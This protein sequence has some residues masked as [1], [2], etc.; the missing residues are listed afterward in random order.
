[1]RAAV[2]EEYGEPLSIESVD[3]PDAEPDGAVVELEA[4]G[5]CRSDWHGWQGDWDWLGLKPPK[6]QILGHEPA[7]RVVEVGPDVERVSEGDHVA[8]PFNIGDGV[9]HECRRG[10]SN[11]CEN[12][13]P[14]GFAEPVPGAFAE[15]VHSQSQIITWSVSQRV[16]PRWIW[17]VSAVGS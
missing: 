1:M 12:V 9:C 11:T 4:C 3:A 10:H 5:I 13:L 17:L 6:G 14:L 7:G 8:V 15:Q 16:S 2:L